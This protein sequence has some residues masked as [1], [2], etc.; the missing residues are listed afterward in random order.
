MAKIL[1]I[2]TELPY[3]ASS[4][5]RI[6]SFKLI[7]HLSKEHELSV[8]ALVDKP[9][10]E[11]EEEF[12]KA[13]KLNTYASFKLKK[14]R[15]LMNLLRSYTKRI[16][17]N[18]FRNYHTKAAEIIHHL[19]DDADIVIIDHYEMGIYLSSLSD[20]TKVYHAHNAEFK[21]WERL[22]QLERE[23]LKKR[24]ISLETQRVIT[25]EKVLMKACAKSFMA[26][27]DKAKFEEYG[28]EVPNF[29]E[30]KHLGSES[31]MSLP[32]L[33]FDETEK[34]L[35]YMG[36]LSWPANSDGL[37]W[38]FKKVW[39][40][41]IEKDADL[42]FH[43]LGKGAKR[44]LKKVLNKWPQVVMHGFAEN[45]DEIMKQCR[46]GVVP[47]RYGSGMKIKVLDNLYRGLPMVTT[48]VGAEGISIE[49][50][51]HASIKDDPMDFANAVMEL[52][53]NED[54]WKQYRDSSRKL[55]KKAYTWEM[56]LKSFEE[57]LM[58]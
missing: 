52:L 28:I 1:F 13:V 33:E 41:L 11:L 6:K 22:A 50:K 26:A 18:Q 34:A 36:S 27:S 43:L 29:R 55:S 30:T 16:P 8:F 40:I 39:P 32:N 46:L 14:K 42:K 9:S 48:P 20:C 51:M 24:A 12:M 4:G 10:E 38:F 5:G 21:L 44:D 3:P 17:L 7:E 37:I 45:P 54:L 35:F 58:E 2:T 47:L 31:L 15:N 23:P 25:A 53:S 56:E 19:A 57:A 49:D